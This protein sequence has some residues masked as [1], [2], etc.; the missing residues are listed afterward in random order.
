M[1]KYATA[2]RLG[3]RGAGDLDDLPAD[4][5]ELPRLH[6]YLDDSGHA[7]VTITTPE[8]DLRTESAW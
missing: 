8:H 4:P 1:M 5:S 2:I 7:D 3:A 6:Q